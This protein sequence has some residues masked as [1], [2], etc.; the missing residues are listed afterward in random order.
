MENQALNQQP[1]EIINLAGKFLTFRLDKEIYGLEIMKVQEIIGMIPITFIPRAPQDVRGVI[2][3][4][5]RIIPVLDM[6][7]KFYLSDKED[8]HLSCIIVV[9]VRSGKSLLNIG[10]VVD[11]VRD[12]Q[13]IASGEI[14]DSLDFGVTIQSDYLL[15]MGMIKE[16]VIMLLD[17]EKLITH[18]EIDKIQEMTDRESQA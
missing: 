12:V 14:D 4:R 2:N 1:N 5:G 3:L 6:R 16:H 9:E 8:T 15:G 10:L 11:E 18:V 17:I 13:D 7:K